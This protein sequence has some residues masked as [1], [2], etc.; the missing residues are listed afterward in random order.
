MSKEDI[1]SELYS[2]DA[3]V[4]RYLVG[5]MT[6]DEEVAFEREVAQNSSL[7]Q[8]LAQGGAVLSRLFEQLGKD[9]PVPRKQIKNI[10]LEK[11]SG[12]I[13]DREQY[14]V[15]EFHLKD[16]DSEWLQTVIPGIELKLIYVDDDGRAMMKARFAP[17]AT[18]PPHLRVGIEECLVLSGDFWA[19]NQ[20]M[21]AGDFVAGRPG[22][23]PLPLYSENGCEILLKI[24]IP[25][26][27][28][29][30]PSKSNG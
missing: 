15:D 1:Y 23:E 20:T 17:G 22:E 9:E 30:K 7:A 13:V 27:I 19:D 24:P 3:L 10:I 26:Q 11:I 4:Q 12:V 6:P 16:S 14:Q 2:S 28:M 21:T 25:Y 5:E 29:S 8:E 18:F